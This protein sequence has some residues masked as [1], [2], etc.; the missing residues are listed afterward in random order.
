[1][2][3]KGAEC[4][5]AWRYLILIR[6]TSPSI[7]WKSGRPN[8][9]S[10]NNALFGKKKNRHRD[11]AWPLPQFSSQTGVSKTRG[12]GRGLFFLENAVLWL[13]LFRDRVRFRFRIRVRVSVNPNPNPK[14]AFFKKKID[15]NPSFYWHPSQTESWIFICPFIRILEPLH[16]HIVHMASISSW[17]SHRAVA[18]I[19]I[20]SCRVYATNMRRIVQQGSSFSFRGLRLMVA[21]ENPRPPALGDSPAVKCVL[22]CGVNHSYIHTYINYIYPRIL[23]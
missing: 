2:K 13:G 15:P 12:R 19:M 18:N 14:T 17:S 22:T 11:W 9:L 5:T 23:V 8:I 21:G 10:Q 3:K 7:H 6:S 16:V 1:M 4:H 20:L